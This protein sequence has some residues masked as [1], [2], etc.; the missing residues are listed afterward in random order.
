MPASLQPSGLVIVGAAGR[1]GAA[2]VKRFS[3]EYAVR[4]LTREELDL[5]D[6]D[7]IRR[8]LEPLEYDRLILS[9][10]LTGVDYCESHE[11]E[12]FAVN[13]AG[14]KHIAEISAAKGAH[15]T[16]ISTDFVFDGSHSQPYGESMNP[17]PLSVYGA[18]KLEGE[19]NVLGVSSG[20]LVARIS[21]LF[22]PGKPAF[23]EW[24]IQQAMERDEL[25]L[26]EEKTGSP[27]YTED[28]VEYL[29]LLL[30]LDNG[31]P[32]AGGIYHLSNSGQCTWREWG[33]FCLDEAVA[34]GLPLKTRSMGANRLDDIAAFVAQRPVNSVLDTSKF[35]RFAGFVP[36]PWQIAMRDHFGTTLEARV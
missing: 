25:F 13:A 34:A 29:E 22:G 17:K 36:R 35:N 23:P 28:V 12:A 11:A 31:G 33:Q 20:N 19:T 1:L 26:P 3:P 6:P 32:P 16:Y 7:S 2:L 10:G 24:I 4:G 18:S 9:G 5:A 27:T 15:V 21:W 14:P 8:T 30:G